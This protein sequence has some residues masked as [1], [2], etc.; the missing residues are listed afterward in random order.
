MVAAVVDI[1]RVGWTSPLLR[2]LLSEIC[3][4]YLTGAGTWRNGYDA[5]A[6]DPALGA[7]HPDTL[8]SRNN[9]AAIQGLRG[10]DNGCLHPRAW[11]T[12]CRHREGRSDLDMRQ[13]QADYVAGLTGIVVV[14]D[15]LLDVGGQEDG[16]CPE[17]E[18]TD[19]CP[20][21]PG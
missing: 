20:L 14:E 13:V 17:S 19:R 10:S 16:A 5:Q 4:D 15:R 9:L 2:D 7:D 11:P 12:G 18:P 21:R 6:S 8:T 3:D 1:R